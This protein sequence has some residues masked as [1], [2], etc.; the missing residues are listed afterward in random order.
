MKVLG[1]TLA[2][3]GS[4]SVPYKNIRPLLGKPLIYY[5][6]KES[7]KC[8]LLDDYIIST[9]SKKI[10]KIAKNYGANV[11]FLRPKNISKDNTTSVDSLKH[12]VKFME[13]L[14][15]LKYDFVIEIMCT[16]PLKISKDIDACVH[17]LIKTKADSVIAVHQLFDH[18]PRRIKKIV[19]DRII[20][21]CLTEKLETRRQDLVPF[22]YIRSGSIYALKRDHLMIKNMRYGSRNSRPY[23]L[24]PNRAINIDTEIDVLVAEN[25]L[26]K[27]LIK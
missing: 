17:K 6:I 27:N 16:N 10:A 15:G 4:K 8:K 19:N 26:K 23:I 3:G 21:F 20:N 11:P 14:N 1:I 18:H 9:D 12:A 24:P 7:L 25:I 5:T 22:A 2:R 13:K